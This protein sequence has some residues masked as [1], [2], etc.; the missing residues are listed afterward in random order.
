MLVS[1][2]LNSISP[3]S[4]HS[5]FFLISSTSSHM[6]L[7][8]Q[9]HSHPPLSHR[10]INCFSSPPSAAICSRINYAVAIYRFLVVIAELLPIATNSPPLIHQHP[11]FLTTQGALFTL[12]H[13]SSSSMS[14]FSPSSPPLTIHF[15]TAFLHILTADLLW[16]PSSHQSPVLFSYCSFQQSTAPHQLFFLPIIR[17]EPEPRN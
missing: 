1:L 16:P 13:F 11:S 14:S 17:P 10:Y 8:S 2:R 5:P 12:F 6:S 7:P 3:A 4:N 15:Y 9:L